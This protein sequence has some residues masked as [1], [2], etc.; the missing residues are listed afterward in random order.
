MKRIIVFFVALMVVSSAS[1]VAQKKGDMSLGGQLTFELTSTSY[2]GSFD[3]V[4]ACTFSI[5][6]QFDYFVADNLRIGAGLSYGILE[7][8]HML[9]LSP[10]IAY[11]VR[12][13]DKFYYTPTFSISGGIITQGG[14]AVGMFGVGLSLFALEYKPSNHFAITTTLASLSYN[15]IDEAT[16]FR[17]DLLNTPS[18]GFK[19]YF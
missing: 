12:L 15:I 19:Y 3:S 17:L 2:I 9:S 6:P 4:T 14:G 13:A 11:Y 1:I 10:N 7:N 16:T 18:V 8:L 5:Q